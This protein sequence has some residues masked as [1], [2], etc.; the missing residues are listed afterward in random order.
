MLAEI[1]AYLWKYQD[2]VSSGHWRETACSAFPLPVHNRPWLLSIPCSWGIG[3]ME[4]S[5]SLE[6]SRAYPSADNCH[7]THFNT[8]N[9]TKQ[10]PLSQISNSWSVIRCLLHA[11][12]SSQWYPP[13]SGRPKN[14]FS[15]FLNLCECSL[16]LVNN[17]TQYSLQLR[18]LFLSFH[19]ARLGIQCKHRFT[20]L[21]N[22]YYG[23]WTFSLLSEQPLLS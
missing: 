22:I 15:L 2:S 10:L 11:T 20:I 1:K 16:N 4:H 17:V 21:A 9:G 12:I 18:I 19:C 5:A 3:H 8:L 23:K 13:I 7:W 14:A 6:S